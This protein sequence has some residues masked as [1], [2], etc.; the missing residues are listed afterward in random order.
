VDQVEGQLGE[1]VTLAPP[2]Q[3]VKEMPVEI[4]PVI[5]HLQEAVALAAL[6]EIELVILPQ[7][8]VVVVYNQASPAQQHTMQVA[9]A[10]QA[11]QNLDL[12]IQEAAAPEAVVLVD[13]I[14]VILQLG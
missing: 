8:T 2:A 1:P 12:Q 7:V 13:L 6:A 14:Q 9:E 10:D 5:I 3:L 11:Q 4:K